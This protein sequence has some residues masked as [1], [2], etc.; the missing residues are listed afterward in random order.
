MGWPILSA[1]NID[2]FCRYYRPIYRYRSYTR[3]NVITK[4]TTYVGISSTYF[5]RLFQ[6][7]NI[8]ANVY[9]SGNGGMN[10]KSPSKKTSKTSPIK[11][12]GAVSNGKKSTSTVAKASLAATS[13]RNGTAIDAKQSLTQNVMRNVKPCKQFN[14][15]S[16]S[17]LSL[18]PRRG[19]ERQPSSQRRSGSSSSARRSPS[20]SRR[21]PAPG[22][23]SPGRQSPSPRRSPSRQSS[24]SQKRSGVSPV[25]QSPSPA[26]RSPGPGSFYGEES[27]RA[28]GPQ[29]GRQSPI[30][31]PP[32]KGMSVTFESDD[33][34][35]QILDGE[36]YRGESPGGSRGGIR[37][38]CHEYA[39]ATAANHY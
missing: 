10:V 18:S 31:Q 25:R 38:L 17:S 9:E 33:M 35:R 6:H 21:S 5:K 37:R 7:Y 36:Y 4:T 19:A 27:P 2:R 26:R 24:T 29:Q 28:R 8:K 34:P 22:R 23:R 16:S 39:A 11:K 12:L 3:S 14:E 15:S 13:K 32:S 20:A 30:R 1:D